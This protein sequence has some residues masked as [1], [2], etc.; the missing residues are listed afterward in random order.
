MLIAKLEHNPRAPTKVKHIK[1][2]TDSLII[3]RPMEFSIKFG[4][5]SLYVLFA[6]SFIDFNSNGPSTAKIVLQYILYHEAN[7]VMHI[8]A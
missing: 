3:F 5:M 2:V 8:I 6:V 4:P 7:I 1:P